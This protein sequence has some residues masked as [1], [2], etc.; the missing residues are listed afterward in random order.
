MTDKQRDMQLEDYS[1]R[2]FGIYGN[3]K[4]YKEDLKRMGGKFNPR[5]TKG[6]GWIF[7]NHL[8]DNVNRYF[9]VGEV[10]EFQWREKDDRGGRGGGRMGD[11]GGDRGGGDRGGGRYSFDQ[12][13][14]E[15]RNNMYLLL[16]RVE[17]L[18][19]KVN[20]KDGFPPLG[21]PEKSDTRGKQVDDEDVCSSDDEQVGGVWSKPPRLLKK[22][23]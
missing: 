10:I 23:V 19:A 20:G 17:F 3:T 6:P 2:S 22:K 12:Q 8:R 1:E 7:A 16:D 14:N 11:R 5:L 18:E 15:M 4:P 21:N 9:D 13:L